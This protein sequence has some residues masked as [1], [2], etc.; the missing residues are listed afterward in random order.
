[1]KR[2][3]VVDSLKVSRAMRWVALSVFIH[4]LPEDVPGRSPGFEIVFGVQS[5]SK[6]SNLPRGAASRPENA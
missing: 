2:R 3:A 5:R 1:M 4:P 6:L